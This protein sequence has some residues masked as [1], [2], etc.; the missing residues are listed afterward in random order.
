MRKK[1]IR[2]KIK[3]I[4]LVLLFRCCLQLIQLFIY[5]KRKINFIE[6]L[7][8]TMREFSKVSKCKINTEIIIL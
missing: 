2:K 1:N 3:E 6:Q 7:L 5:K 8:K 4:K